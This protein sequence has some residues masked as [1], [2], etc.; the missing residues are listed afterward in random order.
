V[1]QW[2]IYVMLV[3]FPLLAIAAVRDYNALKKRTLLN[4]P[5][6]N[7]EL[8]RKW[9]AAG[10]EASKR[11]AIIAGIVTAINLILFF[12]G[13]GVLGTGILFLIVAALV[14]GPR[15]SAPGTGDGPNHQGC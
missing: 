3:G 2:L 13:I 7:P 14:A 15:G 9:R 10:M 4:Y 1:H 12:A 5:G 6:A 11:W 8:F